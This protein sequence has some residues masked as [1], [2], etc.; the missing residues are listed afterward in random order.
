MQPKS[1]YSG[2]HYFLDLFD[3]F[4]ENVNGTSD[5]N[6]GTYPTTLLAALSPTLKPEN[7]PF[8]P[9]RCTRRH[10]CKSSGFPR[11]LIKACCSNQ[12]RM[13]SGCSANCPNQ[14][15]RFGRHSEKTRASMISYFFLTSF[16]AFMVALLLTVTRTSSQ[17]R[18]Q[19]E[20]WQSTKCTLVVNC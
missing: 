9:T 1:Q 4:D 8:S 18:H 2:P 3:L 11:C 10:V 16:T 15:R 12:E 20:L 17:S 14:G 5:L 7:A 19:S 13:L 6:R